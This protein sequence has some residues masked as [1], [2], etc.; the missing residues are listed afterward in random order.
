MKTCIA[1]V[2]DKLPYTD[3]VTSTAGFQWGKEFVDHLELNMYQKDTAY[4]RKF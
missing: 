1:K 2:I 4:S 3:L